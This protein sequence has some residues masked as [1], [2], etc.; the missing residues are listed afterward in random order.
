MKRMEKKKE[1]KIVS[2]LVISIVWIF[3][4]KVVVATVQK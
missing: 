1:G 2:G 3:L 4:C